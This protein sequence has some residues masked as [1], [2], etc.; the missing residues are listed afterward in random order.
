ML[1]NFRADARRTLCRAGLAAENAVFAATGGKGA[2][3]L[4]APRAD[5]PFVGSDVR[6]LQ[7][8]A[9][10]FYIEKTSAGPFRIMA[11][12]DFHLENKTELDYKTIR[13]F[14]KNLARERP[15]LVILTGDIF[16]TRQPVLDAVQFAEMMERT[17]V[18]WCFVFGNHER[19]VGRDPEK[20][21][22][23]HA[24]EHYPHCLSKTGPGDLFGVG[25]YCVNVRRGDRLLASL[26]LLDSGKHALP[27]YNLLHG[28]PADAGGY[29]FIKKDQ[30]AWFSLLCD[31]NRREYGTDGNL[32]FMHIAV[33][34]YE[35]VFDAENLEDRVF[36]PSG[37]AGILYGA[38]YETVGCPAFNSGFFDVMKANGTKAVF[39]GHDHINDFCAEYE[40]V[41][42]VYVQPGG[43][44]T[45]HMGRVF[46]RPEKDWQ[47]G[48]TR[49][50]IADDGRT[51]ISQRLNARFLQNRTEN[52]GL[53][54]NV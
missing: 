34:E 25:N 41:K 28:R 52:E 21:R 10:E 19:G 5:I 29:D 4:F 44:G 27:E 45:Y 50:D 26:F 54:Q 37:R 38:Q 23:L 53:S 30:I 32:V 18:Y 14:L 7:E 22:L 12:T 3:N 39:V 35:N 17:G 48:V 33:P 49:I 24:I 1:R 46:G 2:K 51:E 15:D 11:T 20:Y 43:Y 40:G 42:L 13:L 47:V 31:R 36:V 8:T 16:E 9:G 6:I